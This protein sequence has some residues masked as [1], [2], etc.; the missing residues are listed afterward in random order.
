MCISSVSITAKE[1]GKSWILLCCTTM[2]CPSQTSYLQTAGKP[3]SYV[4]GLVTDV[5]CNHHSAGSWCWSRVGDHNVA[6][7]LNL[8]IPYT[9]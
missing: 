1:N 2:C 5:H 7:V 4:D 6:R 8:Y 3:R 9:I